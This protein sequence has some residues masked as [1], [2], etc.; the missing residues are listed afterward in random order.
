MADAKVVEEWLTKATAYIDT[1]YPVHWPT[2]YS[3]ENA[4]KM[5]D[6]V[7]KIAQAVKEI[8]AGKGG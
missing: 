4:R 3:K 2:N 7:N 8:L 5:Q 1:R 6:A